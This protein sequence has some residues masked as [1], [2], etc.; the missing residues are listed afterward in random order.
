MYLSPGG[1]LD[2]GFRLAVV[3]GGNITRHLPSVFCLSTR[4]QKRP[5]LAMLRTFLERLLFSS[6]ALGWGCLDD[7]GLSRMWPS[8]TD[9]GETKPHDLRRQGFF[10]SIFCDGSRGGAQGELH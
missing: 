2:Y 7:A 9:D 4:I 6:K 10:C 5:I 1:A 3:A 8:T